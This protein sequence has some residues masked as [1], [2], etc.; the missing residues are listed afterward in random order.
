MEDF[1]RLSSV[2]YQDLA[3]P[4]PRFFF[5]SRIGNPP[6][7]KGFLVALLLSSESTSR[8]LFSEALSVFFFGLEARMDFLMTKSSFTTLEAIAFHAIASY[9]ALF[10]INLNKFANQDKNSSRHDSGRNS[11][12]FGFY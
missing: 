11:R 9:I 12:D 10:K 1:Y 3:Q 7:S 8:R 6:K 5:I 2:F 4:Q